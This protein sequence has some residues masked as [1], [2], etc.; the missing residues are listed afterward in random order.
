M[1]FFLVLN[2]TFWMIIF[3]RMVSLALPI[4]IVITMRLTSVNKDSGGNLD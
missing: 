3:Q 4:V 2:I 1:S